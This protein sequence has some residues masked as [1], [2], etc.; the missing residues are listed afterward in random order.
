MLH[1]KNS[2]LDTLF[3][4]RTLLPEY[5]TIQE[6]LHRS[7]KSPKEIPLA[8]ESKRIL[9]CVALEAD[10]LAHYWIDAEYFLLGIL[11]MN[12]CPPKRPWKT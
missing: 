1:D 6:K 3:Y 5:L 11:R 12:E 10:R 8:D 9:A 2:R 7:C 4:L